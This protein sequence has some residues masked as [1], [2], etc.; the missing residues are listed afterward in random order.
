M[1]GQVFEGVRNFRYLGA[2]TNLKNL[3]IDEI[4]SMIAAG[5]RCFY[6]LRQIFR[7]RAVSKAVTIKI[8]IYNNGEKFCRVWEWNNGYD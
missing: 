6:N 5:N 1:N 8:R 4:K 3:I 7:S 2:L